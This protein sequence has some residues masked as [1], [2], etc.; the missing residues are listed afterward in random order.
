MKNLT[1][2]F[3]DSWQEL[4]HVKWPTR[5]QL[6][7]LTLIVLV[8]SLVMAAVTGGLDVLFGTGYSLLLKLAGK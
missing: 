4:A 8:V 1:Q 3:R 5:K 7:E 6:V 2:Y